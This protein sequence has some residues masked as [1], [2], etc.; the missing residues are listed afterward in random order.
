MLS[1]LIAR[2]LRTPRG[3]FGRLVGRLMNAGNRPMNLAALDALSVEPSHRVLEVGFGGGSM[4]SELLDRVP[5]GSVSGLELS[6][7]MLERAGRA[8]RKDVQGG[9]LVLKHGV[10][11]EIP[12]P[13][14]GFDRILTVNTIYFWTEPAAAARELLRVTARTGRVV[15]GYGRVEDMKRLPPTKHGFRLWSPA[16]VEKLLSDAGFVAVRSDERV[17]PRRSFVLTTASR[18]DASAAG[19]R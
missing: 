14:A 7:T 9:R 6:D 10:V 4:L 12:F 17:S 19:G 16:E 11:E 15:V 8:F 13:D 3:W 18:A 5:H 2:H 1:R